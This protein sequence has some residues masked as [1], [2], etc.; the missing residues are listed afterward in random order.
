MEQLSHQISLQK[1]HAADDHKEIL[2]RKKRIEAYKETTEKIRQEQE[3]NAKEEERRQAELQRL[4]EQTR[5]EQENTERMETMRRKEQEEIH[6]R[7]MQD[8]MER[9]KDP[10]FRRFLADLPEEEI[11]NLDNETLLQ[12]QVSFT[13]TLCSCLWPFGFTDVFEFCGRI[14]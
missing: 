4:A 14:E 12:K 13:L 7:M 5:L 2:E 6:R 9:M 10:K 11:Q 1:Y 8:R 3:E